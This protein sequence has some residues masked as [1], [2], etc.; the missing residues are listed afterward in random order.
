MTVKSPPVTRHFLSFAPDVSLNF[1]HRR[2]W[3][4]ISGGMFGQAKHYAEGVE[5]LA[6]APA[7][8]KTLNY[9]GG[10]KWFFKSHLAFSVD[11]RWYSIAEGP[12][13]A[14]D[15]VPRLVQPKTTLMVISAGI[16]VK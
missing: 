15:A 16:S 4:Y 14:G 8:R 3:S 1:G 12:L 10:A 9:G 11:I 2:G 13:T 5:K 7:M 6:T